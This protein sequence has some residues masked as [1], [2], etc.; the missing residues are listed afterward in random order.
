MAYTTKIMLTDEPQLVST[1][2][3][4]L[5][6]KNGGFAFSFGDTLPLDLSV[7]H[8]DTKLYT[9]GEFGNLYAWKVTQQDISLTITK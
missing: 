3:C 7:C 9:N 8:Y 1:G 4:Y 5:Q 6:S 2:A